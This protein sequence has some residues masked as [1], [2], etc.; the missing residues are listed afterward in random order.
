MGKIKIFIIDDEHMQ[1]T[2]TR[3]FIKKVVGETVLVL[4]FEDL[5]S[6]IGEINYSPDLIVTD[7]SFEDSTLSTEEFIRFTKHKL[8]NT[9][10]IVMSATNNAE[11]AVD[12]IQNGADGFIIKDETALYKLEWVIKDI[13]VDQGIYG[14]QSFLVK[15]KNFFGRLI[16]K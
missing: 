4:P 9:K 11:L 6:A 12:L 7:Y 2:L 5:H 8:P 10:I 13:M 14:R 15:I 16:K 1:L 3:M